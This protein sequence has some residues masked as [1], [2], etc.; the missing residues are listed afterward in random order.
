MLS[1]LLLTLLT[2]LS[3]WAEELALNEA[4]YAGRTT[5]TEGKGYSEDIVK[6]LDRRYRCW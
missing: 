6:A 5:E 2:L 1:R 3:L 4:Y